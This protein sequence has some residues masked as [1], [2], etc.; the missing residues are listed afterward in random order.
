MP[1]QRSHADDPVG[2][3]RV[4]SEQD[5][6]LGRVT[7]FS[8]PKPLHERQAGRRVESGAVGQRDARGIRLELRLAAE[9]PLQEAPTRSPICAV[10][11]S[12]PS[13]RDTTIVKRKSRWMRAT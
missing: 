9:S 12:R 6:H 11:G 4:G 10:P 13:T 2:E 5:L 8:D 3:R 1:Q 7:A